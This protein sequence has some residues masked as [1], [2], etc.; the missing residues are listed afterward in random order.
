MRH[1]YIQYLGPLPPCVDSVKR[2]PAGVFFSPEVLGFRAL[3]PGPFLHSTA[4]HTE[5]VGSKGTFKRGTFQTLRLPRYSPLSLPYVR[6]RKGGRGEVERNK[7][8]LQGPFFISNSVE[9]VF[10][11]FPLLPTKFPAAQERR[12]GTGE[13]PERT[14]LA[15]IGE[16]VLV[17]CTDDRGEGGIE[18]GFFGVAFFPLSGICTDK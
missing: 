13:K 12:K 17:M 16:E 9:E 5:W 15:Y 1:T 8:L 2:D 7:E 14:G 10:L 4:L 11:L 3:Y 6:Q 18:G